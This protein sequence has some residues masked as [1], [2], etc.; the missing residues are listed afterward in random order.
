V[1]VTA[2]GAVRLTHVSPLLYTDPGDDLW[3]VLSAVESA[4][5]GMDN[6][7]VEPL[8][9]LVAEFQSAIEPA[10]GPAPS[11]QVLLQEFGSR[12]GTIIDAREQ[13]QLPPPEPPEV[14][15]APQRR[16]IVGAAAVLVFGL[17]IC[18]GLWWMLHTTGGTSS[19]WL[20]SL[21]NGLK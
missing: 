5:A 15:R 18:F 1:I 9:A 16:S 19:G 17:V 20:Q 4:A 10:A 2:S 6:P 7:E 13:S 21:R 12:L 3:G 8:K 11:K 14:E